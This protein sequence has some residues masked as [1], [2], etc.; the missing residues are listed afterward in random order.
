MRLLLITLAFTVMTNC[1][2][3]VPSSET[4][5]EKLESLQG[6]AILLNQQ[7]LELREGLTGFDRT[8]M[9]RVHN[10]GLDFSE[11]VQLLCVLDQIWVRI[12]NKYAYKRNQIRDIINDE[13]QRVLKATSLH[14]EYLS[15]LLAYPKSPA[16]VA[17][18]RDYLGL[19]RELESILAQP[20]E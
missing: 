17:A 16:V 9:D 3:S 6:R 7:N 4:R 1:A 13:A 5:L 10:A 19:F 11:H 18:I 2:Y 15:R 14:V 8:L 20:L 12:D